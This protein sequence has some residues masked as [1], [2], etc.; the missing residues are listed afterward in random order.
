MALKTKYS[1]LQKMSLENLYTAYENLSPRDRIVAL[2]AGVGILCVVLL[3][4]LSV[5]SR[6]LTSLKKDIASGQKG[7]RQVAAKVKEYEV[8]KAEIA[9]L[10]RQFRGGE[11]SLTSRV[12]GIAKD[13]GVTLN[14]LREKSPQETDYLEIASVEAKITEASL[15]Q[16]IDFFYKI[17]H[18]PSGLMRV[19]SL[20]I[21]PRLNNRNVLDVSCE[22]ATFSIKKE[23]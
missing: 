12:E 19:Q 17:E 14:Q 23:A 4:P 8:T 15:P 1:P 5:I 21:K 13:A 2:V 9:Q 6:Q 22:I 11:G 7:F 18:A 20:E 16:L 10:E 3:L